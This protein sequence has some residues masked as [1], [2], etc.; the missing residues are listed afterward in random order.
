MDHTVLWPK[1]KA[2][3]RDMPLSSNG[4][5]PPNLR[6]ILNTFFLNSDFSNDH[7]ISFT[8]ALSKLALCKCIFSQECFLLEGTFESTGFLFFH[9]YFID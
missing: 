8:Q 1:Y 2:G 9:S 6:C 7:Y 4:P 5:F 3:L